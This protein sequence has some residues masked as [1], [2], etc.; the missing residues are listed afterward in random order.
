MF[1]NPSL[2]TR[3]AAGKFTGLML[4]IFGF[5]ITPYILPDAD[6]LIR[7]GVLLWYTTFGAIIGAF[8]VFTYHPILKLPMPWWFRDPLIGA[9]M[10]FVMV[11]F[12]YDFMQATMNHV[13][14]PDGL[15]TSPWWFAAEGAVMG[16]II[17]YAALRFGGE[18]PETV[19][20]EGP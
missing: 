14:G 17:G 12:T 5:F 10:N 15:I 9:W 19:A 6:L 16:L 13:F 18:G 2:M 11:F 3:I 7:W 20:N 1:P 4:G 8:G